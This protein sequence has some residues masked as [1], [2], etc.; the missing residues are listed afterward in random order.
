MPN[1]PLFPSS[2]LYNL[3]NGATLSRLS[4]SLALFTPE[5]SLRQRFLD[6]YLSDPVAIAQRELTASYAWHNGLLLHNSLIYVPRI[7]RLNLLKM[8]HDDP[9]AAIS[10]LQKYLNYCPG[11]IGFPRCPLMSRSTSPRATSVPA[12]N[13]LD[14]RKTVSCYRYQFLRALGKESLAISSSTYPFPTAMM[15]Y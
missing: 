15:H 14:T 3:P 1:V 5:S 2:E 12:Q 6:T 7:L 10:A 8:H 11:I 4:A 13:L 9:L